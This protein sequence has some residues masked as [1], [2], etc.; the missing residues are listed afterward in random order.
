MR[1]TAS[2]RMARAAGVVGALGVA[3]TLSTTGM[4]Q[5]ATPGHLTI[6]NHQGSTVTVKF[7]GRGGRSYSPRLG[8]TCSTFNSAGSGNERIDVYAGNRFLGSSIYN[9]QRGTEVHVVAGPSFYVS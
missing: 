1:K 9:G 3:L 7:P 8:P 4:A 5:A 6:C 2:S